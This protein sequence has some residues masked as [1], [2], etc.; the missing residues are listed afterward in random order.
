MTATPLAVNPEVV[1]KLKN[2]P[3]RNEIESTVVPSARPSGERPEVLVN[4]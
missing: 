3:L 4:E 2:L 1:T